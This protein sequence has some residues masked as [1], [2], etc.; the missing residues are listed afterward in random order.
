[1]PMDEKVYFNL[2]AADVKHSFWIPAVGG[3]LDNNV[4]NVNKFY[5]SFEKDSSELDEGVFFGKCAELCGPSHA[6][7]DFKV[8][9]MPR[10]EFDE[11]VV[12]MQATDGVVADETATDQGE[13][14]FAQ[15]CI[16][17]HAVSAVGESNERQGPNLTAFGDRNR[18]AGFM[19]HTEEALQEWIKDPE[20]YKPAN[21]MPGFEGQ[22]TQQ[23][24]D[25]LT[26]YLMGLTVEK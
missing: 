1:V 21:L 11:W 15:S 20:K 14:L 8:K 24:L 4:E 23:E 5:L 3:K 17:C 26:G 18:V 9:T 19:D 25:A 13:Q 7:M 12:A 16:Q 6:L 22:F 2:I 10:A